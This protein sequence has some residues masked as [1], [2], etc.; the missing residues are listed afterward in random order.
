MPIY[1]AHRL[2]VLGNPIDGYEVNDSHELGEVYLRPSD[3][4]RATTDVEDSNAILMAL[5]D[6]GWTP[7]V[8]PEGEPAQLRWEGVDQDLE[9][10]VPESAWAGW[11]GND[12]TRFIAMVDQPREGLTG[13]ARNRQIERAHAAAEAKLNP[14]ERLRSVDGLCPV[15]SLEHQEWQGDSGPDGDEVEFWNLVVE[16]KHDRKKYRAVG[17]CHSCSPPGIL[18][19][20]I[21]DDTGRVVTQR[22]DECSLYESDQDAERALHK[23]HGYTLRIAVGFYRALERIGVEV[24]VDDGDTSDRFEWPLAE[25]MERK[26]LGFDPMTSEKLRPSKAQ[27][28]ELLVALDHFM[29]TGKKL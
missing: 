22:C 14:G 7:G 6:K 3:L 24:S 16:H 5:D 9:V 27:L 15:L 19:E 1:T 21:E 13:A 8:G 28:Q 29:E 20:M 26:T 2:D 4:E 12:A 25:W 23:L 18:V 11:N 10:L 17:P